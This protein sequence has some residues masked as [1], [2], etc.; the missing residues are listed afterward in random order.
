MLSLRSY[1]R[2]P[3]EREADNRLNKV[4]AAFT[5]VELIIVILII[6]VMMTLVGIGSGTFAFW[7]E[8]GFIR[9]LSEV[10]V[11]LHHQAPIDQEYY[12]IEFDFE[13]NQYQVGVMKNISN[14]DPAQLAALQD[15]GELSLEL[16][17]FLSPSIGE[18]QEVIPPPS[19]PS[20]AEPE[21]FP[22]GMLIEDVH[23]M[24]GKIDAR[25]KERAYV[26]FSPRG[27]SEFAVIHLRTSS[28]APVTIAVN[29]FT[30]ITEI[31]R[32]YKEFSPTYG[33]EREPRKR[34]RR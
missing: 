8:E 20:L 32:E 26:L 10:M 31:F 27:F 6:G 16:A 28:G 9:K 2:V 30:G 18:N 34:R 24:R 11:F 3:S 33:R 5:L 29:P 4:E 12:R 17:A 7:R 21:I 13:K 15:A 22:P 14:A 23:T 19:F 25:G 1:S